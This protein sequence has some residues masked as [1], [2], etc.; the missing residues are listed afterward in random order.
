MIVQNRK[1]WVDSVDL[2]GH[3]NGMAFDA[4]HEMADDTV[5]GDSARSSLPGLEDFTLQHE[6]I[7]LGGTGGPDTVAM[8]NRSLANVLATLTPVNGSEGAIA[9][10]MLTT[11]GAYSFG[12]KVGDLH[13]FS[14]DLKA[15]GGFPAIRGTLMTNGT[16][17]ATGSSA[18]KTQLGAV[19]ATQKLYAGLHVLAVTGTTPTLDVIVRSD[20]NSSPGSETTRI[21]FGQKTAIGSE[22][23]TP[24][25]GAITDTYWDI[26][27][28]I[29]GT[30]SPTFQIVVVV[31]IQ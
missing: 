12:G 31:G 30:S 3:L 17:S 23:A 9:Y 29:G 4:S 28:T 19:S 22:W 18:A 2:S 25:A 10:F 20:A 7:W 8:A 21:T 6:G 26:A 24:I 13:Q 5:F 16:K 1:L 27:W 15:S 11:E 14:V